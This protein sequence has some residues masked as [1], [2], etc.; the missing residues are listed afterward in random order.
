[1]SNPTQA[2]P[3]PKT[4]PPLRIDES[5]V[6]RIGQSR[7]TLDLVIQQYDNGMS[8]EDIVRAYDSLQLADVHAVISYYLRHHAEV[9]EY[10]LRR[11]QEAQALRAKIEAEHPPVTRKELVKRRN[12]PEKN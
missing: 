6:V 2:L 10:L 5:G 3:L 4:A 11:L 1:M 7:V 12:V 8:A 9:Q